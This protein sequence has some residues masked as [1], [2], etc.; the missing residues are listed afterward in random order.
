MTLNPLVDALFNDTPAAADLIRRGV[1]NGLS[2]EA[3]TLLYNAQAALRTVESEFA[4]Y[5]REHESAASFYCQESERLEEEVERVKGHEKQAREDL[6]RVRGILEEV[7][8]VL[9]SVPGVNPAL[10]GRITTLELAQ[11]IAA[12]VSTLSAGLPVEEPKAATSG[13]RKKA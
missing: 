13:A 2:P 12:R 9:A 6:A 11:G 7:H 10:A 4:Q 3:R 8:R 1:P 5:K